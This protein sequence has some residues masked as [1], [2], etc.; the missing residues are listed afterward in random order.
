MEGSYR[1]AHLQAMLS[2][3]YAGLLLARS[4]ANLARSFD[5]SLNGGF[6]GEI[7]R[8][9]VPVR[10]PLRTDNLILLVK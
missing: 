6:C 8:G 4:S 7:L 3:P 9:A 2:G 5:K 1:P 10:E